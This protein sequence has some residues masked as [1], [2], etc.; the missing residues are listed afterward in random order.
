I[1]ERR[2]KRK[3]TKDEFL[4][5][6]FRVSQQALESQKASEH[7]DDFFIGKYIDQHCLV[8]VAFDLDAVRRALWQRAEQAIG[9]NARDLSYM[10]IVAAR[11]VGKTLLMARLALDLATRGERVFWAMLGKARTVFRTPELVR[12][13]WESELDWHPRL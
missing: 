4:R 10:Q 13:Y 12:Q 1:K 8:Y 7:V 2:R 5:L 9:V 6:L 3:A 11:R